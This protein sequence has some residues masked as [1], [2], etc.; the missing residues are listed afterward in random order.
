[1]PEVDE[2]ERLELR[3]R[4]QIPLIGDVADAFKGLKHTLK[5]G[6]DFLGYSGHFDDSIIEEVRRHPD[7]SHFIIPL[8]KGQ[9]RVLS[10]SFYGA[11]KG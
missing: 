11:P 8:S 4:G 7:V 2:D 9:L 3:K 6:S 5:I 10:R 1:M